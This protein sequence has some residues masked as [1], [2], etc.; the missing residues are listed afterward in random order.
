M[1]LAPMDQRFLESLREQIA[2]IRESGLYKTERII[3]SPQ[4]A[5][6]AV[7]PDLEVIN[8]CANN[9]LGLSDD[10]KVLAA[11]HAALDR[12]GYGISSVRKTRSSTDRVSTR[13]AASSRRSSVKR[14]RSSATRSITRASSMAS[15]SPR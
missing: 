4:G 15:V 9:Y 8:F 3:S 6:I 10:P 5:E 1:M 7:R 13:T 2:S 14:T 12:W 11:A